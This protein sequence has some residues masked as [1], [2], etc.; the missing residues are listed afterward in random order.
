[1]NIQGIDHIEMYVGDARQTAYVLCTAFG[2]RVRGQGGPETGLT[3]QRS[4]LLGQG[5]IRV[6]LTTGLTPDHPASGYV[7]RH[8]DGVVALQGCVLALRGSAKLAQFA[9]RSG[10]K[11]RNPAPGLRGPPG[12]RARGAPAR[13]ADALDCEKRQRRVPPTQPVAASAPTDLPKK[14]PCSHRVVRH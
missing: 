3:G 11:F 2:F 1:M 7:A 8:G 5:D 10:K 9:V 4:I 14:L 12:A 6:L 13:L